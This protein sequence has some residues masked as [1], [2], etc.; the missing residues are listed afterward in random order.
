[1]GGS[2]NKRTFLEMEEIIGK[3]PEAILKLLT[4]EVVENNFSLAV[5]KFVDDLKLF[6]NN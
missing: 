5:K 4:K 6:E 2:G 1:M 3:K